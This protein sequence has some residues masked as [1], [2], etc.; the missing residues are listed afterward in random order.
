MHICQMIDARKHL[1]RNGFVE[2]VKLAY[3]MNVSGKRR[4]TKE[5]IL[6][7]LNTHQDEDIVL[8]LSQDKVLV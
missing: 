4:R 5:E 3:R 1:T 2:I 7:N 6:K 8:S